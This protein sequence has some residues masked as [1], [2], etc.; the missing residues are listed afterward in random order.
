MRHEKALKFHQS[1]I[2]RNQIF[3]LS[4]AKKILI[5]HLKKVTIVIGKKCFPCI[6]QTLK[7][8]L[9]IE[10]TDVADLKSLYT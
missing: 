6:F 3:L 8:L 10:N 1:D 2:V 9:L 7:V 5:N 4:V